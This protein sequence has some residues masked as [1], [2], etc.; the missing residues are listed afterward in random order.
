M[1]TFA[2]SGQRSSPTSP[3]ATEVEPKPEISH[4]I[5][6]PFLCVAM[7]R[8]SRLLLATAHLLGRAM[9][10]VTKGVDDSRNHFELA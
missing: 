10:H 6:H 4:P 5:I 3:V 8:L 1:P 2:R 9:L 7:M